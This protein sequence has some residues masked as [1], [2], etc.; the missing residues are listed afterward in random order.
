METWTIQ[1]NARVL[2]HP[3]LAT[4]TAFYQDGTP[5]HMYSKKAHKEFFDKLK[6]GGFTRAD[7]RHYGT[8][9]TWTKKEE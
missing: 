8:I 4:Y 5:W 2:K 1:K 6:E 9:E 7:K 3:S